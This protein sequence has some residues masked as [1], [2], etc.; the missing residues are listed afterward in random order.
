MYF[1][2][3][4][5]SFFCTKFLKSGISHLHCQAIIYMLSSHMWLMVNVLTGPH[6]PSDDNEVRAGLSEM[7][8]LLSN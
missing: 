1:K 6:S 4:F 8:I 2:Y 5:S 3:C 7:G